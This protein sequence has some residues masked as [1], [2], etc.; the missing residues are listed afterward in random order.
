MTKGDVEKEIFKTKIILDN[1]IKNQILAVGAIDTGKM[2][3]ETNIINIEWD[4]LSPNIT[5][6]IDTTE[7]YKYVDLGTERIEPRFITRDFQNRRAV[8]KAL[9]KLSNVMVEYWV[10]ETFRRER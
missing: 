10:T 5:Y 4:G 9:E 2:F 8:K 6:S 1:E 7:Y 3:R